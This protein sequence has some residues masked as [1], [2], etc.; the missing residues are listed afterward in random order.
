MWKK[1]AASAL[2]LMLLGGCDEQ[3]DVAGADQQAQQAEQKVSKTA[4]YLPGGGGIDFRRR[5]HKNLVSEVGGNKYKVFVY[6]FDESF[7]S[8]DKAVG[9]ILTKNGYLRGLQSSADDHMVVSYGLKTSN[10][11]VFRYRNEI[12]EGTTRKTILHMSWS[13]KGLAE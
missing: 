13:L 10:P 5:A 7:H 4:V 6:E 12:K 2:C 8:V 3:V 9:L 11:V 1:M